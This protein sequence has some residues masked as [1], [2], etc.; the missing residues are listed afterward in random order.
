MKLYKKCLKG[1]VR[2][3]FFVINL[4]VVILFEEQVENSEA[5][6]ILVNYFCSDLYDEDNLNIMR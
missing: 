5:C 2:V 6:L 3:F 4:I 1:V